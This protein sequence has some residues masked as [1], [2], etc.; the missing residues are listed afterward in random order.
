VSELELEL[1]HLALIEK[2]LLELL[3]VGVVYR[4]YLWNV[5]SCLIISRLFVDI[6]ITDAVLIFFVSISF[7]VC[8][9]IGNAID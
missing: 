7:G 8:C 3:S 1:R 4:P 9:D 6:M 2:D 5:W